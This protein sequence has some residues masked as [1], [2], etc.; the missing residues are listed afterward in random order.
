ME[1]RHCKFYK[2]LEN[3]HHGQCVVVPEK[4]TLANPYDC[5]CTK[6]ESADHAI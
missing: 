3:G 1:C 6:F 5:Q 4:H 2:L